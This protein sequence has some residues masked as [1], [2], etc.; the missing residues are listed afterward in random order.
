MRRQGQCE[1]CVRWSRQGGSILPA[2]E[3]CGWL[4]EYDAQPLSGALGMLLPVLAQLAARDRC[5]PGHLEVNADDMPDAYLAV[6]L[7]R[8]PS[9][10]QG[11]KAQHAMRS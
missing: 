2:V 3:G 11:L 6:D 8:T 7:R 9:G 1:T 10:A 5:C 4:A